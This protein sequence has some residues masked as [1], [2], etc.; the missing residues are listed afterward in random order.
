L[1]Y[2]TES[3]EAIFDKAFYESGFPLSNLMI[4]RAHNLFLDITLWSGVVGLVF[5]VGFLIESYKS[6]EDDHRQML[7]SFL[8]YSMFQP[9]SVAHWILFGMIL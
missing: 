1:G 2:G 4:D 6:L 9:L 5:F 7:L 8:I 3:D